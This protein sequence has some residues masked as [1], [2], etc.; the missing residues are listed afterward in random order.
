MIEIE[1]EDTIINTFILFVQTA[2][3]VLK[4]ADAYLYRKANLSVIKL[5]VL[6]ILDR[7][8]GVMT[9]SEIAEWTQTERHNITA[10]VQRMKRDGM[11]TTERSSKDKRTVHIILTDKGRQIL[12]HVVPVARELIDLM[13][14]SITEDDAVQMTGKLKTLRQNSFDIL[15][16]LTYTVRKWPE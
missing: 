10:L 6:Q 14:T 8:N 3:A 16:G 7:H 4:S 15:G 5:I 12:E 11:I 9:P 1:H 2:Q 13:M